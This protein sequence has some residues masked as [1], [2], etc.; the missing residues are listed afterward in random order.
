MYVNHPYNL[1]VSHNNDNEDYEVD[2][3]DNNQDRD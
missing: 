2:Q 1:P 3:D